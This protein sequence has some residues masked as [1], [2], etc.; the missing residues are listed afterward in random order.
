MTEPSRAILRMFFER[1]LDEVFP[2]ETG[3]A[4][5]QQIGLFSLIYALEA[6]AAPVTAARLSEL[7]KQSPGQIS[8]QLQKLLA[9]GLI[10]RTKIVNKQGRGHAWGLSI[11]HT[12][13]TRKLLAA[14]ERAKR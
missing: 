2:D 8:K 5:L 14:I 11:K 3:A 13:Q 1:I 12:P 10:D 4:R 9:I 6:E 7:T